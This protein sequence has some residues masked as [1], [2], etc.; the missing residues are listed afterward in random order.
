MRNPFFRVICIR[1]NLK[2]EMKNPFKFAKELLRYSRGELSGREREEMEN[3][4]E[5]MERLDE[6]A[7]ELG[8]KER[9][10][11][12]LRVIRTFDT[13]KALR[14]INRKRG[15]GRRLFIPW[16][17]AASVVVVAGMTVLFLLN[18]VP[19]K[20]AS[21]P[22]VARVEPGKAKVTFEMASGARFVLD[23]LTSTIRN[24]RANVAFENS[25]GTLRVEEQVDTV[26]DNVPEVGRNKILVPY[27][28]TYSLILADGTKVYLNS[29]TELEFPSRFS[30]EKRQVTLKGEAY[31][32]VAR[33]ENKPF[34]VQVNEM[35]VKVLGTSFNVKSYVDEPGVY[36]TLVE[37][38]VAI[39]RDGQPDK[40]IVPGEQAYYNKGVGTLSVNPVDVAEFIAWKDGFFLFK[41]LPLEEILRIVSRW[42]DV[43]VF[44]VN[45]G[46]RSVVY[47]GKLPMYSSIEDVLRK[48]EI[49][50]EVRF[51]LKGRVLMVYDK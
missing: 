6:L 16:V 49:S 36:T 51:D 15:K 29:G 10:G 24:D 3:V 48:F 47:S 14:E 45:Q 1:A 8:D 39:A 40:V 21:V 28:G 23:T 19:E 22:V 38:S 34:I 18:R 26:G 33:N 5:E 44:Y 27:G 20:A 30:K 9:I 12:E 11:E 4:L 46:A 37:G 32:E 35:A 31:F 50:G 7:R 25:D 42:Y 43:E 17:A 13:E 2:K 41:D